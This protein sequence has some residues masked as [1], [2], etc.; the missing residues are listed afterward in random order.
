M[1]IQIQ[2]KNNNNNVFTKC[3][4]VGW[5]ERSSRK[6]KKKKKS[7]FRISG[8]HVAST[9][10]CLPHPEGDS[11]ERGGTAKAR[12]GSAVL[13]ECIITQGR[14]VTSQH[15]QEVVLQ[16]V[17]MKIGWGVRV[18]KNCGVCPCF[19]TW[20][21]LGDISQSCLSTNFFQIQ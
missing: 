20:F 13:S 17:E 16:F 8:Q 7:P 9:S 3:V 21:Y 6:G 1:L 19:S 11:N 2:L 15:K 12:L 10:E 4:T 14:I 5:V 18:P